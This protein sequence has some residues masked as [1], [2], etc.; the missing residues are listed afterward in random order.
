MR[1]DARASKQAAALEA[2]ESSLRSRLLVLLPQAAEVGHQLFLNSKNSK[3]DAARY[4]H[5]EADALFASA[6]RCI[7]TRAALGLDLENSV[8]GYFIAACREAASANEHRRGPRKL[9]EWL[10]NKVAHGT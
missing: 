4:S 2:E 7:E 10:L 1:F 6:T 9:A 5:K 3:P 8:G